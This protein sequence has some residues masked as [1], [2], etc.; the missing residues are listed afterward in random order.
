MREGERRGGK[1]QGLEQAVL[2]LFACRAR[3][4]LP[5]LLRGS[6]SR[7]IHYNILGF[8]GGSAVR[9]HLPMQERRVQTLGQEDLQEEGMATH[10]SVLA[11]EIPRTEEPGGLQTM[12]LQRVRRDLVATI[13]PPPCVSAWHMKDPES[14]QSSA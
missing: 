10:S 4:F 8:P 6:G 14:I 12:G 5:S 13:L 1:T 2:F 9:I 3:I 11:W 7:D